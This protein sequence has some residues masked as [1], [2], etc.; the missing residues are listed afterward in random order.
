[1]KR[2]KIL[3]A[4]AGVALVSVI[5]WQAVQAVLHEPEPVYKG[6]KL[7]SWLKDNS[8]EGSLSPAAQE[9]V[10]QIG[11][12]GIPTLL[13][14]LRMKDSSFRSNM[15]VLLRHQHFIQVDYKLDGTWNMLAMRGFGVLRTNAQT[16]VPE[17]IQ[18]VNQNI[19]R[20]SQWSA[21]NSLANFGPQAKQAAPS[22]LQWATNETA[23]NRNMARIA[24]ACVDPEAA[25]KAGFTNGFH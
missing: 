9:A 2:V 10:Y 6:R 21:I 24:F 12:N 15:V 1:M 14:L 3:L 23:P 4:V 25:A 8:K 18:I 19:S 20:V 13:R 16:A 7:T 22:L 11:T 17:L 5:V